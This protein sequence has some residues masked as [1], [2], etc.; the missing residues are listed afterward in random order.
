M[1]WLYIY[2]SF[3]EIIIKIEHN[4]EIVEKIIIK[5]KICKYCKQFRL[6]LNKTKPYHG[7]FDDFLEA[8][9]Q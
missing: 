1:H 2:V 5:N 8:P 7:K 4:K 9:Q 3:K 6:K